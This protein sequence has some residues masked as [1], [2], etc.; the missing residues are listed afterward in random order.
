MT[1]SEPT[2]PWRTTFFTIWSGQALSLFGSELVQF[3]LIWWLT[4]K[5]DSATVLAAA[6]LV[7]VLPRVLLS[8]L[9]GAVVDR[10]NRRKL[11]IIADSAIA[12]VTLGLVVIDLLGTLQPWQIYIALALRAAGGTFHSPAMQSST[13]LLVP[14]EQLSRVA[15]MNQTLQ[16]IIAI[17]APPLGALLYG[18]LPLYGILS[19]DIIT[20]IAAVGTLLVSHIP[21]PT[22]AAPSHA[23][24]FRALLH[25]SVSGFR[26]VLAWR[27]LFI[28]MLLAS[29]LNMILNP[30][31]ALI[32]L[33]ITRVFHGTAIQ[34]GLLDSVFGVGMIAGGLALSVW[35]GFKR[36]ILTAMLGLAAMGVGILMFA[37]APPGAFGLVLAGMA[38]IGV[39]QAFTNGPIGAV[40]QAAVAPEMQGRVFTTTSAVSSL[41]TPLGLALAGPLS[42]ALGIRA[43]FYIG[44]FFCVCTGLGSL[45]IRAVRDIESGRAGAKASSESV[46]A[47][48]N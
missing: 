42:D 29:L 5:Y 37:V 28:L 31:S 6:M 41:M 2:R 25:D 21:Q 15:G 3:A 24:P 1:E 39:M 8:P 30:L 36:R 48:G 33:Y 4:V 43:W 12:L 16:G 14:D 38:V 26:Y 11:M 45:L 44:G 18:L 46:K 47:A 32:P 40:V 23:N 17:G 22:A 34:L 13:T 19:I 20:A 27:G 35:G 7:A 9:S 10:Y